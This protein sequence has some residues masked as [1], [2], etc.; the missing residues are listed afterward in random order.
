M[1]IHHRHFAYIYAPCCWRG[2]SVCELLILYSVSSCPS[3]L[4]VSNI[5]DW[6][7][8]YLSSHAMY[9]RA[10]GCWCPPCATD[11]TVGEKGDGL[12]SESDVI[13]SF[14]GH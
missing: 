7:L 6:Q 9:L 5:N 14:L 12:N 8:A 4:E 10:L 3:W 2:P 11:I 13:A 1:L